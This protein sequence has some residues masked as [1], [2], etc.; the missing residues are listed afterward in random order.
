MATSYIFRFWII[1]PIID[2]T[3]INTKWASEV[4]PD[5]A[6]TGGIDV[7]FSSTGSEP[8]SHI[9]TETPMTALM[10]AHFISEINAKWSIIGLSEKPDNYWKANYQTLKLDGS[11]PGGSQGDD[12]TI[13]L[14]A[15]ALGLQRILGNGI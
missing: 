10:W 9:G 15:A 12:W 8:A 7:R 5:P 1:V 14:G 6:S 3:I 13:D 4:D 2:E 11:Y